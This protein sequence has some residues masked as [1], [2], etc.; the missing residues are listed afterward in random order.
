MTWQIQIPCRDRDDSIIDVAANARHLPDEEAKVALAIA[1]DAMVDGVETAGQ[2]LDKLGAMS[3]PERHE[4][5][6][7]ARVDS[8]LDTVED[9]VALQRFEQA[10]RVLRG[11]R[12]NTGPVPPEAQ[13]YFQPGGGIAFPDP[14]EIERERR[15]DELRAEE[16]RQ[17]REQREQEA[18]AIRKARERWEREH[19]DDP[20]ANPFSGTGWAGM[21]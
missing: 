18:E 16:E 8:G 9:V 13:P 19:A 2:L 6:N 21:T 10:N 17:L 15:R 1:T 14:A 11:R 20:Y 3:Q 5:L 4:L 12:R 7:R